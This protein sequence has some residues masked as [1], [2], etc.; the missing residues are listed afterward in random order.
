MIK[1]MNFNKFILN[2]VMN[3][4]N[5]ALKLAACIHELMFEGRRFNL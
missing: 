4:I 5:Y 1:I 3:F 2:K